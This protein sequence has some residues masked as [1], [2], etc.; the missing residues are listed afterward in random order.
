MIPECT[1]PFY[2]ESF[3][4]MESLLSQKKRESKQVG[5]FTRLILRILAQKKM[6][7]LIILNLENQHME[8]I[9]PKHQKI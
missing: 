1:E 2:E 5:K 7:N 3:V 4:K 9:K 8:K 6:R